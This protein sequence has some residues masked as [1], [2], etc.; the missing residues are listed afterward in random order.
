[1]KCP[2][3]CGWEGTPEEYAEHL[4]NCP[5]HR[6][7]KTEEKR[8]EAWVTLGMCADCKTLFATLP[9]P[10]KCPV[11]GSTHITTYRGFIHFK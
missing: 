11:C 3:G 9:L 7:Q 5:G 1:M 8:R 4:K 6:K 10:A 2:W